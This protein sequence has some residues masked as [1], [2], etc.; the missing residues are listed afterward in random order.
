MKIFNILEK[1]RKNRGAVAVAL[2]DPDSKYEKILLAMIH[3]INESD[4]DIIF[5]GGSIISDNEFDRRLKLIKKHTN[6]P[7]IIFPGSSNQVSK[8]ADA[9][10]YLS[11]IS[12]RNPR[13]LI[14]EHVKSALNI[15]NYSLETIPTAYIL[16]SGG[17]RSS[18]ELVSNTKP[19]SIKKREII[20]AHALAGEYLGKSFIF[21]E[22]GSGAK[23]HTTCEILSYLK[24]YLTIPIIVGGGINT[25]E[26][27]DALVKAGADY[28]VTGSKLEEL[29][30][31]A[32]LIKFTQAVHYARC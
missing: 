22:S 2:I 15:Y 24:S 10:L 17:T 20:L 19:L 27:A 5:V 4:F 30:N 32:D 14:H 26:S 9:I 12:G 7:L 1:I 23:Y 16:I 6:L 25:A 3:L 8:Y 29:P 28:I 13:Y 11:L 21:L 31:S 18:V